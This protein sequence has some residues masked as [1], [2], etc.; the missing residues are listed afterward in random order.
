V[1]RIVAFCVGMVAVLWLPEL[2]PRFILWSALPVLLVLLRVRRLRWFAAGLLGCWVGCWSGYRSLDAQLPQALEGQ[3]IPLTLCVADIPD[4]QRAA[5]G[6]VTRFSARV[7]TAANAPRWQQQRLLLSWYAPVAL[8]PG[9][10]LRVTVRLKRPRG[11]VNPGGFDYQAWL[12]SQGISATGYVRSSQRE[13]QASRACDAPVMALRAQVLDE[14]RQ[15]FAGERMLPVL[16]AVVLGVRTRMSVDQWSL[17]AQTGTTHLMVISGLHISLVGMLTLL[18]VSAVARRSYWLMHRTTALQVGMLVSMGP[19]VG[20]ALLAGFGIPVRRA[21]LMLAVAVVMTL[22]QRR[23][24]VWA[25]FVYAILIVLLFDPMAPLQ[26]G[27][28]LSFGAVAGL[29]GGVHRARYPSRGRLFL[30]TQWVASVA[31]ILPWPSMGYRNPCWRRW[32]ICVRSL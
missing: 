18:I 22:W 8:S 28:W 20:Y 16:E 27:F 15:R 17:F 14:L 24:S 32:S 31:L 6:P 4:T 7:L 1:T 9:D 12:L 5:R 13:P 25:G 10:Q 21:V 11:L 2:P 3:D 29:I 26:A 30:R 23:V 19:V